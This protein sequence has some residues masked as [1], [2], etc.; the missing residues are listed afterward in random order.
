MEHGDGVADFRPLYVYR[1]FGWNIISSYC[2]GLLST[3]T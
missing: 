1:C 3:D 2:W